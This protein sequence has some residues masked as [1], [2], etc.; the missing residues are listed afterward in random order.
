LKF[1]VVLEPAIWFYW[2][3]A[4]LLLDLSARRGGDVTIEAVEAEI[5]AGNALL[6][7]NEDASFVGVTQ[8]IKVNDGLQCF[9]WQMGGAGEWA[10]CINAVEEYARR[11]GCS[12]I[13]GAMRP[14]FE[15]ILKDWEKV[16]VVLRKD[17]E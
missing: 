9:I 7:S 2:P 12:S 14:G 6:W 10:G 13:E 3:K 5:M 16:A 15:R 4:R 17:L 1:G 8:L 11:E